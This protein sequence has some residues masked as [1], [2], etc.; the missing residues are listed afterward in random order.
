MRKSR[1]FRWHHV[2]QFRKALK[3]GVSSGYESII[4]EDVR[5][6][7]SSV[8]GYHAPHCSS[9]TTL[10]ILHRAAVVRGGARRS[11]HEETHEERILNHRVDSSELSFHGQIVVKL[12]RLR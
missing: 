10:I 9:G 11:C 5:S 1:T 2:I 7:G 12:F 8:P 3:F 6:Y 4:W